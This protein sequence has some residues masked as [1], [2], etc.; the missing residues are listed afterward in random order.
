MRGYP[1][2]Q[3]RQRSYGTLVQ[4]FRRRPNDKQFTVVS[5]AL[6]MRNRSMTSMACARIVS[7][8]YRAVVV[9]LLIAI[10]SV[11]ATPMAARADDAALMTKVEAALRANRKLIGA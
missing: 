8:W 11:A 2:D 7:V 10:I 5:A 6:T 3:S 9:A 1:Y 4:Y